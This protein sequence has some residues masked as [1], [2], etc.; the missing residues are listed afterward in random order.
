MKFIDVLI[1]DLNMFNFKRWKF[2]NHE[3]VC[4]ETEGRSWGGDTN[5]SSSHFPHSTTQ[6]FVLKMFDNTLYDHYL[7]PEVKVYTRVKLKW[8]KR[9]MTRFVPSCWHTRRRNRLTDFIGT[10]NMKGWRVSLTFVNEITFR[11]YSCLKISKVKIHFYFRFTRRSTQH[12]NS[13]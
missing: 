10:A 6:T 13:R 3:G 9:P 4:L 11:H 5:G 2:W 12:G 7:T 1:H 8:R